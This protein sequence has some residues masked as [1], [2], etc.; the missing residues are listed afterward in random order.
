MLLFSTYVC[1]LNGHLEAVKQA[2]KYD[3]Y[4]GIGGVLMGLGDLED[5][6]PLNHKMV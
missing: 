1:V 2:A 3:P 5:P 4:W 6:E